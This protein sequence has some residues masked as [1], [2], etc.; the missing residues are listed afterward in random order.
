MK[1]EFLIDNF[2]RL[3]DAP[4][5]PE[6]LRELVL[7]LAAQGKLLP[8][9]SSDTSSEVLLDAI[10]KTKSSLQFRKPSTDD[11]N[12]RRFNW[13]LDT[14]PTPDGWAKCLL[15]SYVY[16]EMGQSPPSSTYNSNGSGLPFF[17]GK[18]EFGLI[19][20]TAQ[21]WCTHPKKVSEINDILISVRA[22]VGPT[23]IADT[24]CCIG[25]GLAA[26]RCLAGAQPKFLS[27]VFRAYE[28]ELLQIGTGTTFKAISKKDLELLPLLVPPVEEQARIVAKVDELMAKCDELEKQQEATRNTRIRVHKASLNS[29]VEA[30]TPDELSTAWQRLSNNFDAL[31]DTREAAERLRLGITRLALLGKL[32]WLNGGSQVREKSIAG[33]L[34]EDDAGTTPDL[35]PG[36]EFVQIQDVAEARLDKMLDKNKNTGPLRPYLRNTNVQWFEFDLSDIKELQMEDEEFRTLNLQDGDLLVCEG[37]EPGR[38]AI[39]DGREPA[40][41]FQKAI[42]RVRPTELVD[43][44]WIQLNLW[45][46]AQSG[47]LSSYFTGATIKHFTGKQLNRYLFP[48]PPQREQQLILNWLAKFWG[49]CDS[50]EG[51]LESTQQR[52][53]EMCSATV[54]T[55]AA[56]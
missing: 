51:E 30:I 3:A 9:E 27:I 34:S 37:G 44:R 13:S 41:T 28:S 29:L 2:E 15:G 10:A 1:P 45:A 52:N 24:K 21:V 8:Q 33:P 31:H 47:A 14:S 49:M 39:W 55:L 19:S 7:R 42:H 35:P 16:I 17:Q 6:G 43:P 32:P 23:N 48:Q 18:A 26:L 50:L 5:G 36:W 40:M 46:D 54:H 12:A 53:V 25:R 22:P 56:A 4:G 20:P 11:P 38:C